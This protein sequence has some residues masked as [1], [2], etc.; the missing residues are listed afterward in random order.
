[1]SRAQGIWDGSNTEIL[2]ATAIAKAAT[3]T[4]EEVDLRA[5]GAAQAAVQVT[6]V[7]GG[8]ADGDAVVDILA[9]LDGTTF[10]T[11]AD[12]SESVSYS[13]GN[14]VVKTFKVSGIPRFKVAITNGNSA[15]ENITVSAEI[16]RMVW[17]E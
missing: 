12:Q 16:R 9:S 15:A 10:D 8:S 4:S 5:I 3:A 14:T 6:V 11:E 2:E 17:E 1:M 7:F 13:A